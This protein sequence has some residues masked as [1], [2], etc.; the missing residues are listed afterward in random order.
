MH[1]EIDTLVNVYETMMKYVPSKDRQELS[2]SIV[3]DLVDMLDE[4]DLKTFCSTDSYL[5]KSYKHY[6]YED[7]QVVDDYDEDEGY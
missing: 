2:D 3:S 1:I 4:S 7:D 6:V 5:K